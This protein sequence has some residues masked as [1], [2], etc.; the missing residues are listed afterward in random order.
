MDKP[1]ANVSKGYYGPFLVNLEAMAAET[2]KKKQ[3]SVQLMSTKA[4]K[5][6]GR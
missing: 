1:T 6:Q 2:I 4:I 5:A 3:I